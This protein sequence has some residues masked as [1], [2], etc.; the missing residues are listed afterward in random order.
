M[1]L[2]YPGNTA[3]VCHDAGA[4]NI[5]ITGLLET[6]R[7]DWRPYMR[8][9][10]Q[11]LWNA[12]FPDIA[13]CETVDAALDGADFLITG[14]GWASELE[15]VSRM[16]AGIR[17]IRTAAVIDHWV[18]YRERFIRNG[19][20]VW[21]DEFWVTDEYALGIAENAFPGKLVLLVPNYYVEKQLRDIV[22][23]KKPD[24]P[25]LLYVLEPIR[26]DW[27]RGIPGEFQALDYFFSSLAHIKCPADTVFLLRPH[28]SE[29]EGKYNRWIESHPDLDI[30][31]D[32]SLD[33]AESLGRATRVAGCQSFA[34]VLA[35][36]AG[37]KVYC[38]LPPWAPPC[39]LPH[40]KLINV[41]GFA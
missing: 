35:L 5:V 36:M 14:T 13:L 38:S 11:K 1:K 39:V 22:H 12:A 2:E 41:A 3:V 32:D 6:G 28:P 8:G 20:T 37:R 27:G 4:A 30:Q 7:N 10:A 26:S 9:P 21:P 25:E 40:G 34:L 18:N 24:V 23:I 33:L 16:Q 17:G 31:L 15:H 19:E 29:S